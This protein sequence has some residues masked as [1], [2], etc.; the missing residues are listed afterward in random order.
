MTRKG[1]SVVIN[2]AS[3]KKTHNG[4]G[5]ICFAMLLL[6]PTVTITNSSGVGCVQALRSFGLS[7]LCV[8][9]QSRF[10]K[11]V[12]AR[13]KKK[14]KRLL[15]LLFGKAEQ[16]LPAHFTWATLQSDIGG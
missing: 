2:I 13:V 7:L 4:C 16:S 10:L 14:R 5:C 15:S 3:L 11:M 1:N 6:F 12:C 9:I 8:L